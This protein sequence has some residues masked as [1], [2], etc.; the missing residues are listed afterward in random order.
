M[1]SVLVGPQVG[2][3]AF[4]ASVADDVIVA[5]TDPITFTAKDIGYYA[6]NINANDIVTM[7]AKPR[8]F[9]ATLLL[10]QS[11]GKSQIHGIFRQIDQTCRS[12]GLSLCGGHTEIVPSIETPIVV[13]T[14]IGTV[15]REKLVISKN[16]RLGDI[17]LL[18]KMLAIEGTAIIA[19]ERPKEA[20]RIL[21]R[22][23]FRKA[24]RFLYDPGISVVRDAQI[25]VVAASVNAMH[26]PTEGGLIWGVSELSIAIGKGIEV[27]LDR[28]PIYEET[29]RLC[30]HFGISPFGLIASGSLLIVA[31]PENAKK[32]RRRLRKAGI[33]CTEIGLVKSTGVVF[34]RNG[35]I[36][37]GVRLESDE[38]CRV[39]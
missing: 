33:H 4:A 18:T 14:M 13:G 10:P 39:L 8:W 7:G 15:R 28:V 21:G 27:D 3:D 20:L 36:V 9:L 17:V 31:S 26:D 22:D 30:N 37:R 34:K 24:C 5:S 38:I 2:E 19:N 23:G 1:P 35:K 25:A 12:M 29:I 32:I 11:I 6:V 16:A